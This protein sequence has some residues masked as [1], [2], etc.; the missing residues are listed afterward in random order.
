MFSLK[1]KELRWNF[2]IF[3]LVFDVKSCQF[4]YFLN[5][6][7]LKLLIFHFSYDSGE[8]L[9]CHISLIAF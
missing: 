8:V 6:A 2:I 5:K 4:F 1:N 7:V 3:K 9:T